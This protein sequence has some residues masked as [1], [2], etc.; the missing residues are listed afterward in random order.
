MAY[1]SSPATDRF[2]VSK[3]T[4]KGDAISGDRTDPERCPKRTARRKV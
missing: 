3:L 2:F 1:E 4:Q